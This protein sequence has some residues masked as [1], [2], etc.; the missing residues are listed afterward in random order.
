MVRSFSDN[1][2]VYVTTPVGIRYDRTKERGEKVGEANATFDE[3]MK[4]EFVAT[5][6]IYRQ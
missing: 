5:E 2:L 4:E 3:F 6:K 1:F